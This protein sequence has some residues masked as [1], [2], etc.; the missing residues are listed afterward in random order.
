MRWIRH[1]V[2]GAVAMAVLACGDDGNPGT[3]SATASETDA[4]T[5]ASMTA[6]SSSGTQGTMTTGVSDT[7]ATG[8]SS[9]TQASTGVDSSSGDSGPPPGECIDDANCVVVDDCCTCA[10]ILEGESAPPCDLECAQTA[11]SAAGITPAAVCEFG[12]CS[13]L[14]IQCTGATCD[15]AP[16]PCAAGTLPGVVDGC[17]SGT[18]VPVDACAR[19]DDCNDCPEGEICVPLVA[20]APQQQFVCTHVPESCGGTP[21]CDCLGSVCPGEFDLCIEGDGGISCECSTC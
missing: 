19:V 17:W 2:L 14:P 3:G 18:C 7:D 15:M 13:L 16:P 5:G 12:A 4:S 10:A 11:C 20:L 1:G 6:G 9:D 21:N 8:S